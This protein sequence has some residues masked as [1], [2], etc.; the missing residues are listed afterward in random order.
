MKGRSSAFW[1]TA[2]GTL[3]LPTKVSCMGSCCSISAAW[4][5]NLM[6]NRRTRPSAVTKEMNSEAA[7]DGTDFSQQSLQE[8]VPA[9]L[10]NA[11]ERQVKG[12]WRIHTRDE[13]V[14]LVERLRFFIFCIHQQ[15]VGTHKAAGMQT[16]VNGTTDENLAQAGSVTFD[17]ACQAPH[18]KA[19]NRVARQFFAFRFTELLNIYLCR[20]ERV[21]TQD[22][23]W[24]RVIHKHKDGADALCILLCCVFVQVIIESRNPTMKG[25]AIVHP[26]I[27]NLL[28]KHA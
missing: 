13:T 27:K 10:S 16:S 8:P 26:G 17:I 25:C 22:L 9:D 19:W 23:A 7:L 15:R 24:H 12:H 20:T 1:L 28:L 5:T 6:R 2:L 21:E 3:E 18:A 4:L 14:S 11:T